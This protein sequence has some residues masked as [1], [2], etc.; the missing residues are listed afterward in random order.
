MAEGFLSGV[1]RDPAVPRKVTVSISIGLVAVLAVEKI[2]S[3][4]FFSSAPM[5]R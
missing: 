2:S 3:I 1:G 5:K 4:S